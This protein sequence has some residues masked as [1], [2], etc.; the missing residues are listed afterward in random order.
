MPAVIGFAFSR[1]QEE[2]TKRLPNR[3]QIDS[4]DYNPLL[5]FSYGEIA[6]MSRSM[7]ALA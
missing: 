7:A 4:G 2:E 6:A 1:E 5:G 3:I